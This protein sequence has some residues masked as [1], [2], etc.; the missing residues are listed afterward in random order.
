MSAES[1]NG[2]KN[3]TRVEHETLHQCSNSYSRNNRTFRS[4]VFC[5]ARSGDCMTEISQ[6]QENVFSIGSVQRLYL[7]NRNGPIS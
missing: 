7:E 4:G 3:D 5:A 6:L 2:T 1:G